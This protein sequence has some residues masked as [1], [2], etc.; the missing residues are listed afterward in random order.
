VV[1]LGRVAGGVRR[2]IAGTA[3]LAF[4]VLGG[5]LLLFP[6]VM[7]WV[8]VTGAFSLAV[9][10]LLYGR[11]KRRAREAGEERDDGG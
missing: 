7:S 2:A 10:F 6:S 8:L 1:A 11:Q 9:G 4:T 5:L 3:A